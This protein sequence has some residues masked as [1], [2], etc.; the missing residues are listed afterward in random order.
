[1][2]VR[3]ATAEWKGN[4]KEGKGTVAT[5]SG[6]LDTPYGFSSR[7]D[8]A[9]GSNPE[10]LIAAAHASCF[11]MAFS[12]N[13]AGAGFVPTSVKTEASVYL[14]KGEGGFGISRIELHC[15][16]QVPGISQEVFDAQAKAAKEGCPISRALAAVPI[17]LV[18]H[19]V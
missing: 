13:L 5:E 16:A 4:L 18:A 14:E 10:E 15:D 7:F 8:N 3:K 6:V 2:F 11:S 12:N 9:G 17:H 1:M 19:L